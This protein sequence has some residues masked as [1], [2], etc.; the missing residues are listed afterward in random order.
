MADMSAYALDRE[1]KRGSAELPVPLLLDVL[2]RLEERA[3]IKGTWVEKPDERRR[4]EIT[5][6]GRRGLAQ[7]RRTWDAFVEAVR[8]GTEPE[9]A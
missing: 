8:R 9:H 4:Y 7:L 2:Y 6:D 1:L 5:P 3:W